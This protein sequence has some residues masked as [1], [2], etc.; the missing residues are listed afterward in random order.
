MSTHLSIYPSIHLSISAPCSPLCLWQ[1][2]D[3]AD[4]SRFLMLVFLE[5]GTHFTCILVRRGAN[6]AARGACTDKRAIAW[7]RPPTANAPPLRARGAEEKPCAAG[8]ERRTRQATEAAMLRREEFRQANLIL[9]TNATAPTL[10]QAIASLTRAARRRR[11]AD[12]TRNA[13]SA[14]WMKS[15][16]KRSRKGGSEIFSFLKLK[17]LEGFQVKHRDDPKRDHLPLQEGFCA[18]PKLRIWS[19][20][21]GVGSIVGAFAFHRA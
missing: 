6:G 5:S 17:I 8:S 13:T 20:A 11:G 2:V 4:T 18:A 9:R 7:A 10:F 1:R 16:M 3:A 12:V 14:A 21:W 15:V 19:K